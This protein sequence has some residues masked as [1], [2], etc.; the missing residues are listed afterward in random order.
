MTQSLWTQPP[1]H[2]ELVA[3]LEALLP[4][5]WADAVRSEDEQGLLAL[6]KSVDNP[7]MVRA[8]GHA[9]WIAPHWPPEY[10]GRGMG[11]GDAQQVAALL[12]TWEV[13]RIPRGSAPP[14]SGSVQLDHRFRHL[15]CL[16]SDRRSITIIFGTTKSRSTLN[17][18]ILR[19]WPILRLLDANLNSSDSRRFWAKPPQRRPDDLSCCGDVAK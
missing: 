18:C 2:G 14:L 9:G 19:R 1:W 7:A 16:A 4:S 5:G 6:K 17:S 13:N 8:L 10:G 15:Q 12:D 11:V 3:F